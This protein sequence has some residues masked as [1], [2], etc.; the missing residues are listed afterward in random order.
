VQLQQ[1]LPRLLHR[2]AKSFLLVAKPQA[3]SFQYPL[4]SKL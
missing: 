1:Q 4:L 3:S 2:I